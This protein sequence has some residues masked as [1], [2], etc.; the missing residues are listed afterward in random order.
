M[1]GDELQRQASLKLNDIITIEII[2]TYEL[3]TE[4]DGKYLELTK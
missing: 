4:D 2:E 1:G 3:H